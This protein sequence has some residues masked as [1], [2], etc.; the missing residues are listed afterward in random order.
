MSKSADN[1]HKKPTTCTIQPESSP[2]LLLQTINVQKAEE[3]KNSTNT[4]YIEYEH[5]FPVHPL[6]KYQSIT[7]AYQKWVKTRW[8]L[9]DFFRKPIC[10]VNLL[11]KHE[12]LTFGELTLCLPLVLGFIGAAIGL[13]FS[14]DVD[15]SGQL[16]GLAW[17]ICYA[18][19]SRNSLV[20]FISGIPFERAL[21]YHKLFSVVGVISGLLHGLTYQMKGL[22]KNKVAMNNDSQR[23]IT[24]WVLLGLVVFMIIMAIRPIRRYLFNFFYIVHIILLIAVFVVAC[25]H[26]ST[27][28]LAGA[29]LYI[30]DVLYRNLISYFYYSKR[31]SREAKFEILPANVVKITFSR[32]EFNFVAGQYIFLC[33]PGLSFWEWHPFT[34]SST[35]TADIVSIHVRALGNWTKALENMVAEKTKQQSTLNDNEQNNLQMRIFIDGPYGNTGVNLDNGTYEHVLLISGGIG[36]TPMLSITN[37]LAD[38]VNRGRKN[39]KTVKNIWSVRDRELMEA[40]QNEYEKSKRNINH[41]G[42]LPTVFQPD[43]LDFRAIGHANEHANN[44]DNQSIFGMD[45][46]LTGGGK[47]NQQPLQQQ[48][49]QQQKEK[50]INT[51]YNLKHGR[52]NLNTIFEEYKAL[53][54]TTTG[55]IENLEL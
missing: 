43:I 17:A 28:I 33:I 9:F 2:N 30:L 50:I 35:P 32:N 38:Q 36:I 24:G 53:V 55:K 7:K 51:Y 25:V 4:S 15:T 8:N 1:I 54:L 47:K 49:Q 16:A 42:S 6:N 12:Y 11:G 13:Y 37:S 19:A 3:I 34:I 41:N 52:P 44:Q 10:C 22:Q 26:G 27:I 39:L 46:Y 21:T 20:T 31:V 5:N 14:G 40:M 45:F 29:A 18:T 48:Q 23:V